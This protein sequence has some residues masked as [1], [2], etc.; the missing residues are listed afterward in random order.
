MTDNSILFEQEKYYVSKV[1][2]FTET[3][4]CH[5]DQMGELQIPPHSHRKAQFLYVQ[6]GVIHVQTCKQTY[7][8][9]A[10]H[11]MWI[12][13]GV[14]HSIHTNSEKAIMRNLY[15]PVAPF[16]QLGELSEGIYPATDLVLELLLFTDRWQ[17]NI[18]PTDS[19]Y[20][21]IEALRYI[22]AE[23]SPKSL[24]HSVPIPTDERLVKII[25]Y[26]QNNLSENLQ[27]QDICSRYGYTERSLHRLFK[28]DLGMSFMQ[29]FTLRRMLKAVEFLI[30]N[31]LNIKEIAQLV[32]YSSIPTF[33]NTFYKVMG[34]RPSDYIRGCRIPLPS[35]APGESS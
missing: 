26:M 8:L 32:G 5:H 10:R 19:H 29:Y 33:S 17:G 4:Y 16:K 13:A 25:D 34:Q 9:P 6:G 3:V 22:V 23:I 15:F 12:P 28:K 35:P 27:Y 21:V 1:D 2:T 18:S 24:S 20:S 14:E 11:F 7:F 30:E 31:K